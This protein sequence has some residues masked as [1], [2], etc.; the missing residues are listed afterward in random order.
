M[1]YERLIHVQT[2]TDKEIYLSMVRVL[3]RSQGT[4]VSDISEVS[5]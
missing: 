4:N 5:L 1:K 3:I 2:S